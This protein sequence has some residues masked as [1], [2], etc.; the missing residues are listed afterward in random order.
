MEENKNDVPVVAQPDDTVERTQFPIKV[1]PG[2][3]DENG[4]QSLEISYGE[5]FREWFMESQG[6]KRWSEKRFQKVLT[7][8]IVEYYQGL[9]S[10]ADAEQGTGVDPAAD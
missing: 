5:D 7:P 9:N 2:E 3:V 6:L 1:V 10:V 4:N 8:R